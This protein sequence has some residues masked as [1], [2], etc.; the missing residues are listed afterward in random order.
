MNE[1][2]IKYLVCP[3]CKINLRLTKVTDTLGNETS[4]AYDEMGNMLTQTDAN[5][6][7]TSFEYDNFGRII[8]RTLPLGMAEFRS[9]DAIGNVISLT[10]FISGKAR[11]N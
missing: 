6:N 10:D 9:Y 8:K 1:T 4:Y 5:G 2:H 7:T 3:E 11:R